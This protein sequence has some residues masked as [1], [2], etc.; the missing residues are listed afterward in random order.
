MIIPVKFQFGYMLRI[1]QTKNTDFSGEGVAVIH[2]NEER[3]LPTLIRRRTGSK[4]WKLLREETPIYVNLT[5][6]DV[7]VPARCISAAAASAAAAA[8]ILCA[9]YRRRQEAPGPASRLQNTSSVPMTSLSFSAT[10]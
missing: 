7:I 6:I 1:D 10:V 8:A 4:R 5:F 3:G 2:N 9:D